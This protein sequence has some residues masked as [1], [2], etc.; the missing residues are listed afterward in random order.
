MEGTAA[1]S[2]VDRVYEELKHR[3]ITY[4]K[5]GS[6]SNEGEMARSLGVSRTPLREA[7][8]RL[9]VAGFLSV[10]PSQGFF[11]KRLDPAEIFDLCEMCQAV[12][13]ASVRLAALRA[14]SEQLDA[15]EALLARAPRPL[16][17][18]TAPSSPGSTRPFARQS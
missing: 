2:V 14:T 16:R 3:A 9:T 6:R 7:L 10:S 15:L 1:V 4:A 11:R 18:R 17:V 8:N 13:V 5:P 12:E